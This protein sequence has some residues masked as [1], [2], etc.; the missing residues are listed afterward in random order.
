MADIMA[1][2]RGGR[3]R[4]GEGEE[5]GRGGEGEGRRGGR[6]EQGDLGRVREKSVSSS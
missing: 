1:Q 6:V 4:E 2:V 3:P 5:E